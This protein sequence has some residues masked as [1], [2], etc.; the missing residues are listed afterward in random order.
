VLEKTPESIGEIAKLVTE[1]RE[2]RL[3]RWRSLGAVAA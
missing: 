2:L 1:F 3:P